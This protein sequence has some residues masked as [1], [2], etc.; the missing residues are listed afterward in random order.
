MSTFSLSKWLDA[1]MRKISL[2]FFLRVGRNRVWKTMCMLLKYLSTVP[3]GSGG[4]GDRMQ[5]LF[6]LSWNSADVLFFN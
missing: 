4:A 3:L 5:N 1:R 6:V 2:V